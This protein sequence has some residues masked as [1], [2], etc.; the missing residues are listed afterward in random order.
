M[1]S[2]D[3]SAAEMVPIRLLV[4]IAIIAAI[5]VLL[6]VGIGMLRTNLAQ[7]QVEQQCHDLIAALNTMVQGGAPRDLGDQFAPAGTTRALALSLPDS[8]VYLSFGGDP[9][10]ENTGALHSRVTNEGSVIYYR[11]D[12]GSKQVIWLSEERI[13]FREGTFS[14]TTWT[15]KGDAASYIIHRGGIITLVCELVEQDHVIYVLIHGN[16]GIKY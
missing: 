3:C 9:D 13:R 15:L 14:N 10:V 6:G 11:V 8:L 16:D 7:H 4:S 12:G 1:R 5:A 2:F